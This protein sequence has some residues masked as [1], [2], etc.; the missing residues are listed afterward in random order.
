MIIEDEPLVDDADIK[1]EELARELI[2]A[3]IIDFD[4]YTEQVPYLAYSTPIDA[5]FH[6]LEFGER[7]GLAPSGVFDPVYY[8]QS[9]PDLDKVTN[10][11]RHFLLHGR[12]EGRLGSLASQVIADGLDGLAVDEDLIPS[13]GVA[14]SDAGYLSAL[15]RALQAIDTD[16]QY[17]SGKFYLMRYPDIAN[18][19][20]N[21]LVHYLKYGFYEGRITNVG[22]S[23]RIYV[24]DELVDSHKPYIIVGIHEASETGAPLVG[25]ELAKAMSQDYN[26]VFIS[27]LEGPIFEDIKGLFP[28]VALASH[29]DENNCFF[30]DHL[31][32]NYPIKQAIFSSSV[33][34]SFI[35]AL[36]SFDCKITC[37]VHEFLEYV[38]YTRSVIYLC[39]LLIF[40]SRQLLNSWQYA[41]DDLD[42]SPETIMVLP[43]PAA[44]TSSRVMSKAEARA[45]VTAATGLD[46]EDATLVLGA[47][48]VQIRK[49]TD[50][51]LQIGN[52]LQREH[53]KFVTVW[54]GEQISEFEMGFGIW[55]HA[56]MER[57]RDRDGRLA[58]HFEAPG[59]LYPVL[60]DAADVFLVTSRL[61]P[62]PNVAL[63][64]AA[65]GLPIIAFSG[66]TG[67]ADLAE[68]D[69]IELVEVEMGAVDEVV[70]AIKSRAVDR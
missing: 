63:D 1:D 36:A 38:I 33:C 56:Q 8:L 16:S 9:Y 54:I 40:S 68:E 37:L 17:F 57:S 48:K 23:S 21:P 3:G 19:S 67:L 70:G 53:G 32:Q 61:D 6:Y 46:L 43:Q 24:N 28:V 41:L 42:R 62:L 55:F 15:A 44:S 5:A 47:G 20:I 51:F 39:D 64:A 60:M 11:A 27:L 59:P 31:L 35:R 65:R 12:E 22:L 4:F 18:H 7:Q 2:T 45:E 34:V 26:V 58:V 66:A 14:T 10:P 49:G 25:L 50:I 52:Q 29:S 30:A 13:P 69:S